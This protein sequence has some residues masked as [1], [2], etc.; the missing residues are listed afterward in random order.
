MGKEQFGQSQ[1]RLFSVPTG[2]VEHMGKCPRTPRTA[3]EIGGKLLRAE[4]ILEA[5]RGQIFPAF[6]LQGVHHDD[7][8]DLPPVE[9]ANQGGSKKI[10]AANDKDPPQLRG[11]FRQAGRTDGE[12][13]CGVRAILQLAVLR[14]NLPQ[15]AIL[16]RSGRRGMPR[17]LLGPGRVRMELGPDAGFEV[18]ESAVEVSALGREESPGPPDL[19]PGFLPVFLE[20]RTV[21]KAKRRLLF[22]LAGTGF[23]RRAPAIGLF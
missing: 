15:R 14:G 11:L 23:S 7:L 6:I 18:K 20:Q 5:Q 1:R 9:M 13:R 4:K 8:P 22:A 21:G 12:R 17:L 16:Q 2:Q 19:P 3:A 10:H